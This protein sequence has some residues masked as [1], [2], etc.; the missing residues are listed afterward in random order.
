VDQAIGHCSFRLRRDDTPT[1]IVW[2]A[3]IARGEL[4][5]LIRGLKP[6]ATSIQIV[7]DRRVYRLHR[8]IIAAMM[9]RGSKPYLVTATEQAKSEQ[10]ALAILKWM[11]QQYADRQA[12]VIAIGGGVTTDLV[13][14]AASIYMRGI[15]YISIPTTLVGMVDAAIGGKTAI[16]FGAAKNIVG[17]FHAPLAVVN[18]LDFLDTLGEAQIRDGL[19]EALKIF[20]VA[21]SRL[22]RKHV[23]TRTKESDRDSLSALIGDAIRLKA[24]IV[25]RDP[26]EKDLRRVLNFG[27]TT[28]HAYEA[29]TG[30]SH[31][32]SVAFGILVALELS[33]RH[34]RLDEQE[35]HH[36]VAVI[37]AVYS[38]FGNEGRDAR[39]LWNKIRHDK[40]RVG[41]EIQFVLIEKCGQH[42]VR[43]INYR[44][45]AVAI[46]A[47]WKANLKP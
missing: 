3:G 41:N 8:K 26:F 21:D 36:L 29:N 4:A 12:L 35:Y 22:W 47:V 42:A 7:C 19:I 44:Q 16:N 24:A 18:D 11:Q 2:G 25:N 32:R 28:G 20:A 38:Q 5:R 15:R 23:M 1:R 43:S 31:G 45:F 13:G 17:T 6:A 9:P 14:F 34:S 27:H 10:S 30:H 46:N 39:A 37:R 33:H 40:K